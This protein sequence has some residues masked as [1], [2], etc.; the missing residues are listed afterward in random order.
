M[1]KLILWFCA[2]ATLSLPAQAQITD[3]T[4][5]WQGTLQAGKS[6]R[7]V[8]KIAKADAVYKTTLYSIDQPG[9]QG[10]NASE[11]TLQAGTLKIAAP[12]FGFSYEGKLS[13]DGNTATGA[14]TQGGQPFPLTLV[15][16]T[17]ETAWVIPEAVAPPKPMAADA[18]PSFDVATIK[19]NNTGATSMQGLTVN[20]RNF[21]TKASSLADL[22]SFAYE[23]QA[24]QIVGAPDWVSSDRFDIAAVPDVE[25]APNPK[26]VRRMIQ[27]LL[28]ERFKLTFH[29]EQREMSAFVL[30]VG[31]SGPKLAS[32]QL[33]GSLP[34]F[35]YTLGGGGVQLHAV[36]A[37]IHDLS[38]Y[39]QSI[40]LDR[41][42]VDQTAL[43]GKYDLQATFTPDD[44][45]FNG[46]PPKLPPTSDATVEGAPSLSEAMQQQLG[47]K[48]EAK[49]T[50]VDVLTIDH[51]EKYSAN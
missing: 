47:L 43:T 11:T 3:L 33:N 17:K 22:I 2:L 10:I 46:H 27:K 48:L 25:G 5:N 32:T 20:G 13:P 49:K 8:F 50:P 19:P 16:S 34:G 26:Q 37:T 6:L 42:V 38:G 7:L 41:P 18:D 44:T 4:G 31:K 36:N 51:V 9:G 12:I 23:V 28:T 24:K 35:F 39:L 29:H 1:N 45:E 15:R 21:A 30:S 40:V 14:W